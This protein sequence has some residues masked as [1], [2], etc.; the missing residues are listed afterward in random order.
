MAV[1]PIGSASESGATVV[2]SAALALSQQARQGVSEQVDKIVQAIKEPD[3]DNDDKQQ[4]LKPVE[5]GKDSAKTENQSQNQATGFPGSQT[6][7]T[8]GQNVNIEG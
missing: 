6:A 3:G 7:P 5:D 8:R 4:Q 1:D 2:T